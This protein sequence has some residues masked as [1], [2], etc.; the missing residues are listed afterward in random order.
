MKRTFL[1]SFLIIGLVMGLILAWQFLTD[2]PLD[3]NFPS[4]ELVAKSELI[5]SYMDE[6]S[7]LQ[8]R[9]VSLHKQIEESAEQIE[10]QS[11]VVNFEIL[12]RL[13]GNVGLTEAVGEG[14]EIVI[15]DSSLAKRDGVNVSNNRLVQASDI[16]DIVNL[17]NAAS[18]D[19]ITVNNQR[20]IANSPISSVGTTILI[21]NSNITPPFII[22]VIGD[23]EV[24]L[25]R[26]LN[27]DLLPDIYSRRKTN[28]IVFQIYKKNRITIP[29]YNGDL[30][31]DYLNL[32]NK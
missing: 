29:I 32:V 14:L 1:P 11:E 31:T 25:Q 23:S 21:N 28:D 22:S 17:L 5:K 20:V 12:N 10:T 9:I 30:K 19:A 26:I 2:I 15:D 3:S 16:R 24:M 6:Q 13:K 8:S 4:D 27:E 18:A 7:Y